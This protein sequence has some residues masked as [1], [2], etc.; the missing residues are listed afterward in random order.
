MAGAGAAWP[1]GA[2]AQQA[3]TASKR[4]GFLFSLSADDPGMPKYL[5]A[6]RAGLASQGWV[7]GRNLTID[8]RFNTSSVLADAL[9]AGQ[10]LID[11]KPDVLVSGGGTSNANALASLTKTIPL[12]FGLV[13]DSVASPIIGNFARP[14]GNA[15]GFLNFD[16]ATIAG[17]WLDLLKELSPNLRRAGF[18]L[19]ANSTSQPALLPSFDAAA[20]K[21]DVEPVHLAF[22][23]YDELVTVLSSF[24][25]APHVGVVLANDTIV[26]LPNR[27]QLYVQV[28][29]LK[30]PAVW[31]HILYALD[32][33]PVAYTIDQIRMERGGGEYAGRVLNGEKIANL[34][35]QLPPNYSLILNLRTAKAIGVAIP[36]TM[37]A[38]ADQVT[39]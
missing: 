29:A 26:L 20:R 27:Q 11:L 21:L 36:P 23:T 2:G 12:I 31:G 13:S 8:Y 34:P 25:A 4:L 35:A 37:I 3:T 33:A 10:E 28:A 24:A 16:D 7:E 32:G 5:A 9:R 30:L 15:T 39:E 38:R 17:K 1:L 19:S 22:R 14:T 6:L 18:L